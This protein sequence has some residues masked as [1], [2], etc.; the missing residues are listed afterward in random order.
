M[1]RSTSTS[2]LKREAFTVSV[3]GTQL[4]LR[5]GDTVKL[6]ENEPGRLVAKVCVSSDG[7]VQYMLEWFDDP[8]LQ[9]PQTLWVTEN[10]L[11]YMLSIASSRTKAGF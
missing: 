3:D 2:Q 6:S 8:A 4:P 1:R 10:E 5:V 7:S 11:S 9:T